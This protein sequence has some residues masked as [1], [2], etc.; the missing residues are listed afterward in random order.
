MGSGRLYSPAAQE[1]QTLREL[2]AD[3]ARA[4]RER[5]SFGLYLVALAAFPFKWLSPFGHEQAGWIDIF[6]AAAT[7]AWLVEAIRRRAPLRLRPPHYAY[8]AY[9]MAGVISVAFVAADRRAGAQDVLIVTEL[10][11]LALLTADY[12]RSRAGRS[13]IAVVVLLV[14]FLTA[15]QGALGLTLYYFGESSSL[16]GTPSYYDASRFY[17]RVSG[18]FFSPPLLGSF[19][20]FA[21]AVLAMQDTGLSRRARWAG[22]AALGALV[23]FTLSRAIIGFAIAGAIRLGHAHGTRRA[24]RLAA[25][26]S[27]A[28]VAAV[29]TLSVAPLT[30]GPL[31]PASSNDANRRVTTIKTSA[32]TL[33]DH[34]LLGKGAGSL[35][36]T[37]E[38][39]PVPA[40]AHLTP[41]NVAA[42][43][44]PAALI[45]LTA[46][47]I[48]LWRRRRRPT[49]V[50]LWS[51]IAGL[52]VDALAHDVEHF[53]HVW[54][55]L[56][57]ADADRAEARESPRTTL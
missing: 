26:F 3:A 11:A 33:A 53:R 50:P 40:R 31:Q 44:G 34:P 19:C 54:I 42:T 29:A 57:M 25:A 23:V 43:T 20:I 8:A 1:T 22:Q 30:F 7:L 14:T 12:A 38:D 10:V 36:G 16:A 15:A 27:I 56:G 18:G 49:N 28:A 32:E 45:A 6:I 47:L 41:L 21:S 35:P 2:V 37:L 13:A 51:G 39:P 17:T 46:L 4:G 24:R 52:G 55:M 9:V 5:P 48:V